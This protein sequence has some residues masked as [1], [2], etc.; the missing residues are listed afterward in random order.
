MEQGILYL[1]QN[2]DKTGCDWARFLCACGCNN[3]VRVPHETSDKPGWH[4][5]ENNKGEI[6]LG[7][8]DGKVYGGYSITGGDWCDAHYFVKDNHIVWL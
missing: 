1:I 4:F 8:V 2:K 3:E 6:T 7:D 5:K